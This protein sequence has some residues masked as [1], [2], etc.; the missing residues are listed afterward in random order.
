[1][2]AVRMVWAVDAVLLAALGGAA[3]AVTL[4][5]PAVLVGVSATLTG[6]GIKRWRGRR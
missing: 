6:I 1:M 3:A 4:G 5:T 2:A